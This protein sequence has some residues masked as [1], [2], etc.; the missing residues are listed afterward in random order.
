MLFFKSFIC[1]YDV[2]GSYVSSSPTAHLSPSQ[3]Q[4]LPF[5]LLLITYWILWKLDLFDYMQWSG[6]CLSWLLQLRW[7]K[8]EHYFL[9]PTFPLL[10]FSPPLFL[11]PSFLP[12][13]SSFFISFLSKQKSYFK[14]EPTIKISDVLSRF[15]LCWF[16]IASLS[17]HWPRVICVYY[18]L[19]FAW[20]SYRMK[21]FKRH[22]TVNLHYWSHFSE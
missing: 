6:W 16:I 20:M 22:I 18:F 1:L 10:S 3:L 9:L 15:V 19:Y 5:K 11:S 12:A 2:C 4:A 21:K 8:K 13:L 7:L 14:L 17:S